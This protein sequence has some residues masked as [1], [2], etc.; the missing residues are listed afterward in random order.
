MTNYYSDQS[1]SDF[2]QDITTT[3]EDGKFDVL[4]SARW[5]RGKF[6]FTGKVE[7]SGIDIQAKNAGK[8]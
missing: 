5:H 3:E 1:G 2:T 8:E 7:I 4:R 6:E